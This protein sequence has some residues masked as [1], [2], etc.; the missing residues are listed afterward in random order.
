[1]Y[2]EEEKGPEEKLLGF[3]YRSLKNTLQI[4]C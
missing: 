3:N 1:M 2:C 4:L